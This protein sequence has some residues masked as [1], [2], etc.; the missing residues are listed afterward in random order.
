MACRTEILNGCSFRNFL[1]RDVLHVFFITKFYCLNR[2][3]IIG[4]INQIRI[5][6]IRLKSLELKF[7][8]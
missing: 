6:R 8:Q 7:L 1:H 4:R 2:V 5:G 3:T